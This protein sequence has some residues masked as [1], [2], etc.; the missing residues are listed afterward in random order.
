MHP[1]APHRLT[2]SHAV[3]T[4]TVRRRS[5]VSRVSRVP[6]LLVWPPT[7]LGHQQTVKRDSMESTDV[8]LDLQLFDGVV[9]HSALS[10]TSNR[11]WWTKRHVWKF[12]NFIASAVN[13]N[14]WNNA[15][16]SIATPSKRQRM[17]P[18]WRLML[19]SRLR[20]RHATWSV[21]KWVVPSCSSICQM[22]VKSFGK[23][24]N[25]KLWH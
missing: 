22:S 17:W 25:W 1:H 20:A 8:L 18:R 4:R 7:D 9:T 15:L 11:F 21:D 24:M 23:K 2:F 14:V 10:D 6:L 16:H 5:H 3:W 12:Q 13:L 19:K